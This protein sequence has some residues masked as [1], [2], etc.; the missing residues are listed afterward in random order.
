MHRQTLLRNAATAQPLRQQNLSA[1]ERG[2]PM[3]F[4]R[5]AENLLGLP[6]Q[7]RD[8]KTTQIELAAVDANLSN[9]GLY[10][11]LE[12]PEKPTGAAVLDQ[13]C[14]S[15]LLEHLT[16]G[17]VLGKSTAADR[18]PTAVDAALMA[19]VLDGLLT[20]CDK[21]FDKLPLESW[22]PDH[23]FGSMIEECRTLVLSL[24]FKGFSL[25]DI[26][27]SFGEAAVEG[28]LQ[29]L[30]PNAKA[31]AEP[32]VDAVTGNARSEAFH[33]N[34]LLAP[35]EMRAVLTKVSIS[36]ERLRNLQPGDQ[37][38]F[39]AIALQQAILQLQDGQ[40]IAQAVL[41]QIKGQRAIR[42]YLSEGTKVGTA[43]IE[44]V[45][46]LNFTG[47]EPDKANTLTIPRQ[48]NTESVA[49]AAPAEQASGINN[50]KIDDLDA[51]AKL[52]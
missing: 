34:L 46:H 15:A 37:L 13:A 11:L 16:M 33:E 18:V 24:A 23:R 2:L 40:E 3:A 1:V 4:A 5:A 44:R 30:L 35:A 17:R 7:V 6:L 26:T 31:V 48:L 39:P 32:G 8:V 49:L 51:L 45:P 38:T 27:L 42:I 28:R 20:E 50:A 12:G 22:A 52:S 43:E 41:G 19:P 25:F 21:V 9:N 36:L 10:L 14:L 29:L 47:P